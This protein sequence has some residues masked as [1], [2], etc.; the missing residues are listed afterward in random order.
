[1]PSS[2]Q[3]SF[4]KVIFQSTP[5]AWTHAYTAG[6]FFAIA[7]LAT[8][9]PPL[10]SDL[11]ALG[12]EIFTKLETEFF[13]LENK[14]LTTIKQV[15]TMAISHISE[16]I[17]L[18]FTAVY[19]KDNILYVFIAGSGSVLLKR[20]ENLATIL[21]IAEPNNATI[22]AASGYLHN[23]D[24]IFL[25][26]QEFTRHITPE[27]LLTMTDHLPNEMADSL[28]G[29][30]QAGENSAA[31]CIII[32]VE[33]NLAQ[34]AQPLQRQPERHIPIAVE[35][36][37]YTNEETEPEQEPEQ[38]LSPQRLSLKSAFNLQRLHIPAFLPKVRIPLKTWIGL[39]IAC[40]VLIVLV[41]S[42][43]FLKSNQQQAHDQQIFQKYYP[44]AKSYF[45]SGN[46]VAKVD[47]TSPNTQAEYQKAD[48][49]LKTAQGQLSPTSPQGKQVAD[50]LSQVESKLQAASN[51]QQVT[52]SNAGS[53]DSL[54]LTTEGKQTDT[55]YVTSDGTTNY[56]I[57]DKGI[58]SDDK[59]K[60]IITNAND[61][62]TIG[63]FSTYEGNFYVLDKKAGILKYVSGSGG[64]GKSN[65]FAKDT[66]P[67][68]NN[69]V[70]MTIDG[71]IYILQSN[72]ALTKFT[73]GE[74]DTF[75]LKGIDK[76]L[77]SPT[78]VFT[79]ADLGSVYVLDNG[80]SRIVKLAKDGTFQ[81]Q[82]VNDIL[83]KAK[84]I[85][86]QESNKKIFILTSDG[87]IKSISIQ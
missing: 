50:L 83:N 76:P 27:I 20:Q 55:N 65:Y 64:Y 80:N 23:S 21:T 56:Y 22:R 39:G 25:E 3:L 52:V 31:G 30:L 12:K 32:K 11:N 47:V 43:F 67:D 54:L 51:I 68:L 73:K 85:D 79:T 74:S 19:V 61:W 26:T 17:A 4:T 18:S 70:S 41:A 44:Q 69:A 63:G 15:I 58:F 75:N 60:A 29:R 86:V 46:A 84:D 5:I 14:N 48:S 45:D 36:Q 59:S 8:P 10:E 33:G 2:L 13:T 1:M 57:T 62:Q 35:T 6:S 16:D 66:S 24:L 9:V 77:S 82:Y 81:A 37:Q 71:S 53:T 49:L 38:E 7:S 72:G 78:R 40:I 87:S 42:I 34:I 28:N